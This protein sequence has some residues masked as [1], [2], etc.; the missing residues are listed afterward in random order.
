VKFTPG[1][2]DLKRAE[3]YGEA[4]ARALLQAE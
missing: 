3:D 1:A 2:E 4:F